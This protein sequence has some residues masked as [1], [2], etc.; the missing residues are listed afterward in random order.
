MNEE[1]YLNK[2]KFFIFFIIIIII[3]F[4][5]FFLLKNS[6]AIIANEVRIVTCQPN[7]T[8]FN[9]NIINEISD[10][11]SGAL[12]FLVKGCPHEQLKI[13]VKPRHVKILYEDRD[14]FIK[15]YI[16][17]DPKKVPAI[18]LW[19]D[20]KYKARIRLK[21]DLSNNWNTKKKFS[22]KV[23]L[24]NPN[25]I[26]E[27]QEF[28]LTKFA[29]RQFPLNLVMSKQLSNMEIITPNFFSYRVKF[30]NQN[31]GLMLAEEQ[32]SDIFYEKRKLKKSPIFKFTNEIGMKIRQHLSIKYR[33]KKP[34]E[35]LLSNIKNLSRKQGVLEIDLFNSRDF[36]NS[37]KYSDIISIIKTLNQL[38]S[39]QNIDKES[40]N[41]IYKYINFKKFAD[42]FLTIFIWGEFHSTYYFNMR[43][44]L[45]PET[46]KIEPIPTDHTTELININNLKNHIN[47]LQNFYKIIFTSNEFLSEY[48]KKLDSLDEN[49]L[50][51][52]KK[53]TNKLC[54]NFNTFN[55]INNRCSK[56]I[57][58][59]KLKENLYSI[60]DY[61]LKIFENITF[62]KTKENILKKIT[63]KEL[64]ELKK[65]FKNIPFLTK[66]LY[67]RVFSDGEFQLFNVTPFEVKVEKIVLYKNKHKYLKCKK[68]IEDD[69]CNMLTKN[70][71][72]ILE[73]NFGNN[74]Y[75]YKP[76]INESLEN[77]SWVKIVSYIDEKEDISFFEIENFKYKKNNLFLIKN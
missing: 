6:K 56:L 28:S 75:S 62:N 39:N 60:K 37:N 29:E 32:F 72:I 8:K 3:I 59:E 67:A 2:K 63:K 13:N 38:N 51:E 30:N 61:D 71:K 42:Y 47:Q 27:M 55:N 45:N 54:E 40:L 64:I 70:P 53:E 48:K 20:K 4:S 57:K 22:I 52:I 76:D 23:E 5:I 7:F 25:Q 68:Y 17:F 33:N 11:L 1:K 19:K 16:L 58:I 34:D 46:L 26:N 73:S 65:I 10:I 77:Y 50:A 18:I 41:Q 35:I 21:G 74:F 49:F 9:D 69:N 14:R 15:N 44:Y 24:E 43:F 12:N 66:N 31:W 36:I